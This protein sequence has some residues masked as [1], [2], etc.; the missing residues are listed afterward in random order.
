MLD[1]VNKK[2]E[3]CVGVCKQFRQVKVVYCPS[4]ESIVG[5]ELGEEVAPLS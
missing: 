2:C 5:E 3:K 1:G 4:Y